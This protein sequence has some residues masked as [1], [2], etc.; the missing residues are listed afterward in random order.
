MQLINFIRS[1][2]VH[3]CRSSGKADFAVNSQTISEQWFGVVGDLSLPS[4]TI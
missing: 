2:K 4:K 3:F 1:T